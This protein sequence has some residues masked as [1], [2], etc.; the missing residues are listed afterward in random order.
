MTHTGIKHLQCLLCAK[1]YS[2]R[3][4][5]RHHL[6]NIHSVTTEHPDYKQCFYA[7]TPEEAGLNISERNKQ[8]LLRPK[9]EPLSTDSDSEDKGSSSEADDSSDDPPVEQQGHLKSPILHSPSFSAVRTKAA[10]K[11][12]PFHVVADKRFNKPL[13]CRESFLKNSSRK[14]KKQVEDDYQFHSG[15]NEGQ[16]QELTSSETSSEID[17]LAHDASD[18]SSSESFKTYSVNSPRKKDKNTSNC[19]KQKKELTSTVSKVAFNLKS[20]HVKEL[21]SLET[22]K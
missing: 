1:A 15:K 20:E 5:L 16:C 17:L 4:S 3:K 12:L 18:S 22:K 21:N 8:S 10:R 11:Q 9:T 13:K 6:L 19:I 2:S 14:I 7:M